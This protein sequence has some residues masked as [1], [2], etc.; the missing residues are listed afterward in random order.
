[1]YATL[2]G[3]GRPALEVFR[4]VMVYGRALLQL[5]NMPAQLV[6]RAETFDGGRRP[7]VP[8][9]APVARQAEPIDASHRLLAL[10][11]DLIAD[12][13]PSYGWRVFRDHHLQRD[14]RAA[15]NCL[16]IATVW[17]TNK[18]GLKRSSW[19]S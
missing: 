2:V 3:T 13:S 18:I 15:V 8:R 14:P 4:W 16:A 9:P 19:S 12:K 1:V 17:H 7:H 10:G 6:R 5:G 11:R